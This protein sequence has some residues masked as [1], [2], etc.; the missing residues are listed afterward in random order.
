MT[1]KLIVTDQERKALIEKLTTVDMEASLVSR[2][3]WE[4]LRFVV[5]REDFPLKNN[6]K[7]HFCGMTK[8]LSINR[9]RV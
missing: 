4:S 9:S 6:K 5:Q 8:N 2:R 7:L 1:V 3:F